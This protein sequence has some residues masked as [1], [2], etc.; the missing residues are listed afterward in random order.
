MASGEAERRG[1]RRLLV[2]CVCVGGWGAKDECVRLTSVPKAH[3]AVQ[4]LDPAVLDREHVGEGD[5]SV[6]LYVRRPVVRACDPIGA[7]LSSW[8]M[9][10]PFLEHARRALLQP[11]PLSCAIHPAQRPCAMPPQPSARCRHSHSALGLVCSTSSAAPQTSVGKQRE[12]AGFWDFVSPKRIVCASGLTTISGLSAESPT[13]SVSATSTT[14]LT[15]S[16]PS[17]PGLSVMSPAD[18]MCIELL[19]VRIVS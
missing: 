12:Q 15:F 8:F 1:A 5:V 11:S 19:R 14:A 3:V 18:M 2:V 17:P 10:H 13:V 16:I 6:E 9:V 4:D 7:G